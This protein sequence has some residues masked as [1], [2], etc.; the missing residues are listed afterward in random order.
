MLVKGNAEL[1]YADLCA[2][3]RHKNVTDTHVAAYSRARSPRSA[4]P[5]AI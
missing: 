3:S 5:R 4:A 1:R 2:D